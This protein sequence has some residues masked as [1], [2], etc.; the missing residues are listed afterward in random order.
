MIIK[1]EKL[2]EKNL[3]Q[4]NSNHKNNFPKAKS[5]SKLSP[6]HIP[7]HIQPDSKT[8]RV[9]PPGRES[10]GGSSGGVLP[11]SLCWVPLCHLASSSLQRER[12]GKRFAQKRFENFKLKVS[13]RRENVN[14]AAKVKEQLEISQVFLKDPPG[15]CQAWLSE[16]DTTQG[17]PFL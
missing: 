8:C 3:Q 7:G 1:R 9:S 17:K 5:G 11:I 2:T 14:K 12:S 10:L 13:Q 6:K 16:W 15:K 4:G